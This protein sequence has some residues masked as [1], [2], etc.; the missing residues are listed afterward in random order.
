MDFGAIAAEDEEMA[1]FFPHSG[2]SKVAKTNPKHVS[3]PLP[4]FVIAK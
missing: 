1:D 3:R 4:S 2:G